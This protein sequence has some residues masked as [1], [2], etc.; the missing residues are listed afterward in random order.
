VRVAVTGAFGFSGGYIAQRLLALRHEVITLTNSPDR[1]KRDLRTGFTSPPR[2]TLKGLFS[3]ALHPAWAFNYFTHEK[4]ELPQL[5]DYVAEGSDV[6]IS[7]GEYFSVMLDQSMNW[8]DAE[9]VRKQW[10]RQFCL[11]GIMSVADARRALDIGATAIIVSN[12]GGRQLDGPLFT[13]SPRLSMPWA[14]GWT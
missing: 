5:K 11:K 1:S 2:L 14:T 8:Q 10:G 9:N 7:I 12:H 4:F 13:S 3:F 6:S